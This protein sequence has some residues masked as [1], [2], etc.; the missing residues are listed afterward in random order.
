MP[1]EALLTGGVTRNNYIPSYII[2]EG[3]PM[4]LNCIQLIEGPDYASE[5]NTVKPVHNRNAGRRNM[6]PF[7]ASSVP[8]RYLK[9]VFSGL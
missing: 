3:F 6:F 5:I 8:Y 2:T 1:A 7:Q 4:L 9:S